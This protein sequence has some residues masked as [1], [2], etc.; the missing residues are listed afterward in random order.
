MTRVY[1]LRC[2]AAAVIAIT[3]VSAVSSQSGGLQP[4]I[5]QGWTPAEAATFYSTPQGSHGN[6]FA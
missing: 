3:W 6:S 5:P 4:A 1:Q 2:A